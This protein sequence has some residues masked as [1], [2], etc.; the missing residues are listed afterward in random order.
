MPESQPWSSRSAPSQGLG[1]DPLPLGLR[2]QNTGGPTYMGA[3]SLRGVSARDARGLHLHLDVVLEAHHLGLAG[4]E[5]PSRAFIRGHPR[6]ADVVV[7]R[8]QWEAVQEKS[9]QVQHGGAVRRGAARRGPGEA[10]TGSGSLSM[11][12]SHLPGDGGRMSQ[13]LPGCKQRGTCFFQKAD[14]ENSE[15]AFLRLLMGR[16]RSC[17]QLCVLLT[18]ASHLSQR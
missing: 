1:P 16:S 9:Q 6:F 8:G 11:E 18:L 4:I 7:P 5:L 17:P 12:M 3:E 13:G 15:P 14:M 10:A 2:T